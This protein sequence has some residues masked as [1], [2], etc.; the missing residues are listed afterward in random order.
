MIDGSTKKYKKEQRDCDF[1][2]SYIV[3]LNI[4]LL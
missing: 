4:Q 2:R 3:M 1:K